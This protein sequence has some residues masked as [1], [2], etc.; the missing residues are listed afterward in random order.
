MINFD[1]SATSFPKP[2]SVQ[3]A[4]DSVFRRYGGNP[5]H[6]GHRLARETAEKVYEVRELAAEMFAAEPEN[7]I[8]T[9]NCTLALNM[10]I[11]G[12][13]QYGGH[14]VL[15]DR[16]HNA[17]ARPVYALWKSRGIGFSVA[18]TYDDDDQTLQSFADLIESNTRA[19]VCTAASN[20]TGRILPYK[21][22]AALCKKRGVPLIVDG[23]QACGV[24]D[25]SL[26]D[27]MDFLCTAGHKAL[28]G[29]SGTGLL[30]TNGEYPL[31][32]IIEGGTGATSAQLEQTDFLPE[33]LESGTLNTVGIIGLGEGLGFVKRKTPKAIFDHEMRLCKRLESR[34]SQIENVRLYDTAVPRVPVLAFNVENLHS[35]ETARLLSEK[36]F[37]LRGGL[38][39]ASLAHR[40]NGTLEQG[41]VRFS[42]SVFNTPNQ[43]EM[44]AAAV[45][46]IAKAAQSAKA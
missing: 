44:L 22:L 7:V 20:V 41:T 17:A 27:G 16:E 2:K 38:Q 10:A 19:V 46:N 14:I 24:T 33:K 45:K 28:Y 32:T 37:A 6:G 12:L 15:S 39:C 9:A 35:E 26:D 31:S 21:K 5:G 1:N 11:K 23:A 29:P 42:P 43:V 3:L 30:I 40:A 25:I 13:T 4:A 34:L 8:F 18:K 36:G